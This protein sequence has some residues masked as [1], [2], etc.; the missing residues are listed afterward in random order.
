MTHKTISF[1]GLEFQ[2]M[3]VADVVAE[4]V[5]MAGAR[6]ASPFEYLVT[7]NV[8]HMIRL[9]NEP[10]LRP[11]YDGA[12]LLVNDSRILEMLAGRDGLEFPAS[13]GADI[14]EALFTGE[15]K[16]DEPVT[17]IGSTDQDV[18]KVAARFGLTNLHRHD[19]PMGLRQKPEAVAAASV[20]M[21]A[22]PARFHFLCVGSP[23]QEMVALAAKELG[24]VTGVGL[25]CG[26]SL[27]FLSGSTARA[28]EWM[29]KARLEWLHRMFSEPGRLAKRYLVDGPKIFNIWRRWRKARSAP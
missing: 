7:P 14:V 13:P 21:A 18:A 22:H 15:I 6:E 11:L 29:R 20:F 24:T 16:A 4:L 25:C 10:N 2:P 8:D 23:Q 19:V 1:L 27:D 26:A 9:E 5:A 12:G 3:P 28:P 17:V